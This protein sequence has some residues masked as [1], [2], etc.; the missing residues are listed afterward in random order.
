MS[1]ISLQKRNVRHVETVHIVDVSA[2]LHFVIYIDFQSCDH[3]LEPRD[4]NAAHLFITVN[5]ADQILLPYFEI[6]ASRIIEEIGFLGL[7]VR[8]K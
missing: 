1:Q 6:E 2:L 8:V 5:I 3:S 7:M 4:V